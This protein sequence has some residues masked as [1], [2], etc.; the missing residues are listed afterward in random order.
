M[1]YTILISNVYNTVLRRLTRT[2]IE[3]EFHGWVT[4]D[5]FLQGNVSTI[6]LLQ[7]VHICSDKSS[8]TA[9]EVN[10]I[11]HFANQCSFFL[12]FCSIQ[13]LCSE[14]AL[15]SSIVSLPILEP[16]TPRRI[17]K[18]ALLALYCINTALMVAAGNFIPGDVIATGK[19][20]KSFRAS[21]KTVKMDEDLLEKSVESIVDI[22]V[23]ICLFLSLGVSFSLVYH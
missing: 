5:Y 4:D 16:L 11:L 20:T 2:R 3:Q 8:G 1:L 21:A 22:S 14:L 10:N 23:S 13:E 15:V 7:H 9:I 18:I 6:F 19:Q 12:L 17:N